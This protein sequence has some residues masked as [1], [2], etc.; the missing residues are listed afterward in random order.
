[1]A[2]LVSPAFIS[3]A[4]IMLRIFYNISSPDIDVEL[5]VLSQSTGQLKQRHSLP[6]QHLYFVVLIPSTVEPIY[7]VLQ[8]YPGVSIPTTKASS[9][10]VT[11]YHTHLIPHNES[12]S[13]VLLL[14]CSSAF[15]PRDAMRER[16]LCCLPVSVRLSVCP[17]VRH[18]GAFYPDV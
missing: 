10:S 15:L 3:R 5:S 9:S 6:Q 7:V 4:S 8:A 13:L 16:G 18:V 2:Y 12:Q 11:M 17:S 1:M 14:R